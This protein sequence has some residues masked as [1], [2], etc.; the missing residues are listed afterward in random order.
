MA[1]EDNVL[2]RSA[3]ARLLASFSTLFL[4]LVLGAVAMG[5][6]WLYFPNQ[7]VAL[8]RSAAVTHEWLAAHA[9]SAGSNRTESILRFLIEDRQ[10]LLMS[11][12][13]VTRLALGVVAMPFRAMFGRD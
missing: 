1:R 3:A 12:V 6:F 10:L 4:S 7:F 8:Q 9:G 13:L 5:F 2:A 11:F